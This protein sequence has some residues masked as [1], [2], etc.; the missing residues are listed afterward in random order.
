MVLGTFHDTSLVLLEAGITQLVA[1]WDHYPV[2]YSIKGQL[3]SEPWLTI[4]CH[5]ASRV[6]SPQSH[7]SLSCVIQHQGVGS[8]QSHGSLSCVIQHQGVGSPQS[9]GSLSCVIQH[10][11]VGSPQSHGSLSCVI[12]HQGVSSP[13]S[14]G[15][16]SCVIQHQGVGSPQNHLVKRTPLEASQELTPLPT[17]SMSGHT[18]VKSLHSCISSHELKRS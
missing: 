5:T 7:G 10:Q 4:L 2:S 14:H 3:S 6:G 1:C 8:P 15:S 18:K 16:L 12:Q 17:L 13:Q 11:G 9:H